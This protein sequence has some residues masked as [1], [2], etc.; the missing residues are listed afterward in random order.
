MIY[1]VSSEKVSMRATAV[2]LRAKLMDLSV[3]FMKSDIALGTPQ[4]GVFV[5]NN[6]IDWFVIISP[7]IS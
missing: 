4:W 6:I 7:S 2:Y 1:E 5:S 3:H